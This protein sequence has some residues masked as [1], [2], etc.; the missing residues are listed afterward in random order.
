ML[1]AMETLFDLVIF[2][3]CCAL[4]EAL[5]A[6]FLVILKLGFIELKSS[7]KFIEKLWLRSY[8]LTFF[9][10]WFS[11]ALKTEPWRRRLAS[12]RVATRLAFIIMDI[13]RSGQNAYY[14]KVAY[15]KTNGKFDL[16]EKQL[17]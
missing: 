9:L 10:P 4:F 2:T 3:V 1:F 14:L 17:A 5:S 12:G 13:L 15:L 11:I 6:R 16:L 8:W 7:K